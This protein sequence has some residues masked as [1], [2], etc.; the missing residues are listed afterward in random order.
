MLYL[1]G[2]FKDCWLG[3]KKFTGLADGIVDE[4]LDESLLRP[5]VYAILLSLYTV[6]F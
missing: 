1:C 2:V 4:H 3:F 6:N 5:C